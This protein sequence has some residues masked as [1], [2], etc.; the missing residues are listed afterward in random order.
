MSENNHGADI[1]ATIRFPNQPE[2]LRRL[3]PEQA[4]DLGYQ[5]PVS[6][7]PPAWVVEMAREGVAQT[8]E[9]RGGLADHGFA[10]SVRAGTKD[11]HPEVKA[12]IA[13][14]HLALER[15]HVVEAR[16]WTDEEL[17]T[18]SREDAA[19]VAESRGWFEDARRTRDGELDNSYGVSFA[20]QA[21]RNILKEGAV[22][23]ST[24]APAV[25]LEQSHK[26]AWDNGYSTAICALQNLADGE[27]NATTLYA[28][29][30]EKDVLSILSTLPPREA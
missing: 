26:R 29:E 17:L 24:K 6:P 1:I 30:R 7:A 25:D 23:G 5:P 28:N 22:G 15:G 8:N 12:A 20:L 4:V 9:R 19:Q 18:A 3:T 10:R 11:D 27:G 14:L 2:F 13:A 21:R 16:E